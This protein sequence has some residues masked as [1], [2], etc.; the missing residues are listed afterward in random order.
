[1]VVVLQGKFDQ[2]KLEAQLDKIVARPAKQRMFKGQPRGKPRREM[3]VTKEG[4]R[5]LY[6]VDPDYSGPYVAVLDKRTVILCGVK[7]HVK[8]MWARADGTKKAKL[9]FAREWAPHLK[10]FKPALAAHAVALGQMVW[11]TQYEGKKK[12]GPA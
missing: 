12:G 4:K 9:K 5:K 1:P 3:A 8:Q 10:T 11:R 2:T 6:R 7:E